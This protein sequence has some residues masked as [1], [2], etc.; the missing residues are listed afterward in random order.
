MNPK[1]D[2]FFDKNT[3]WKEEYAALRLLALDC[4]LAE[5]LK[6]GCPCYTFQGRNIVL[7]HGFKGYCALLLFKG[8]LL[9]DEYGLLIQQTANVQSARQIRFTS[10]GEIHEKERIRSEEHT[11]ELQ[12]LMRISYAVFC[13]KKKKTTRKKLHTQ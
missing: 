8:A 10:V 1:V 11:S 3:Q 13:L 6:W 12:S 5:E 7:I 4:S 9:K 2:W